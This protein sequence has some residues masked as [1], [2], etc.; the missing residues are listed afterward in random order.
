MTRI[1]AL[2][3]G[4]L[5]FLSGADAF[6]Q[7]GNPSF[8]FINSSG[9]TIRELYVSSS[10]QSSWGHDR[11]GQYVLQSGQNIWIPLSGAGGCYVDVRVVYNNG[12]AQE[13]RNVETCSRRALSW[14]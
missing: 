10:R 8:S 6:A 14:R 5:L 13:A 3:L 4:L 9:Y 7:R 12:R 11:L 1:S 2:L